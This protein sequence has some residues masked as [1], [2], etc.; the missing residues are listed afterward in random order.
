MSEQEQDVII[1]WGAPKAE[2][3]E[4][5]LYY[6]ENGKVLSYCGDKSIPG[7]NYIIID[8]QTFAEGRH[9]LRVIDGK[10][11]KARPNQVVYKLMPDSTSGIACHPEDISIVVNDT[12]EHTKWK[13]NVYEL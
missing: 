2:K 3:P 11:S 10:I 7:D 4:L 5:R 6:D 8:S 13:I 1:L 12:E 9:D